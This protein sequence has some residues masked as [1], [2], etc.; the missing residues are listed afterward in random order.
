MRYVLLAAS[1]LSLLS[2]TALAKT[3]QCNA[4]QTLCVIS[5]SAEL[6]IGDRVGVF[7]ND[8]DLVATAE[9]SRMRG[10][11]RSLAIG[12][13]TGRIEKGDRIALLD[14]SAIDGTPPL[15][16]RTYRE[17][18]KYE[19]GA[20]VGYATITLGDSV[21]GYEA[22]AYF[23]QRKWG[24]FELIGRAVAEV[25]SGKTSHPDVST[26]KQPLKMTGLGLLGGLGY[27]WFTSQPLSLRVEGGIGAMQVAATVDGKKGP[28]DDGSANVHV[29]NGLSPYARWSVGAVY[30]Y[31]DHWHAHLDLAESIVYQAFGNIITL[32]LSRD[33]P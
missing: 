29:K 1:A 5:D 14:T 13:R 6:T 30:N 21:P 7:N 10:D 4:D 26:D 23:Q 20:S 28:V 11:R 24:Q 31:S 19:V 15:E 27:E 18:A 3:L 12:S 16:Y 22:S 8:G 25:V 32:G 17:P 9:V 2:T 33:L